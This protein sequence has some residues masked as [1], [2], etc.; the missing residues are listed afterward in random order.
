[1]KRHY[2]FFLICLILSGP[3]FGQSFDTGNQW[4]KNDADRTFIKLVVEEEGIYRVTAQ[5]LSDAGYDVSMVDPRFFQLFH[6]G[7]EVPIFVT[8]ENGRLGYLEF[9]GQLNDGRVDSIMYRSPISGVH[10]PFHQPNIH[11]SIYTDKAA[12]FLTWSQ[13]QPGRRYFD[14]LDLAYSQV[15][16]ESSFRYRSLLDF[17]PE[18]GSP[19]PGIQVIAGGGQYD[20]F[21]SLNS[22]FVTGEGIVSARAFNYN[23]PTTFTI[24]TPAAL[25]QGPP[26]TFETRVFGRSNT[27][28]HLRI[29]VDGDANNPL[30][31]TI[32]NFNSIY[33]RTYTRERIVNL[34]TTTALDCEALR[35]PTD[36]NHLCWAA[37]TYN[38]DFDLLNESAVHMTDWEKTSRSHFRFRN[39]DGQDSVFAYDLTNGVRSR[40][41]MTGTNTAEVIIFESTAAK[42]QLYFTTDKGIKSPVIEEA[43]LNKLFDPTAGA[44]FVIVSHPSLRQAAEAYRDYRDTATANPLSVKLVYVDEIYD[45]F[46]YG[47]LTPWAIKRFCK[48]AIDNWQIKPRFFLF[49]GKGRTW[50]RGF[51]DNLVPTFG[52]PASDFEFVGNYR[53]DTTDVIPQAAVGRVN[54][55]DNAEAFAYLEKVKEHEY[56]TFQ[57]WMKRGVFLGGGATEGEQNAIANAFDYYINEFENGPYGGDAVYFQ[58]RTQGISQNNDAFYHQ[59]ISDGVSLIHFFGHSSSCLLYTSDAADDMQW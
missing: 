42:R 2:L 30:V 58:K 54:A 15:T 36:N 8:S 34:G 21:H 22:D 46:G 6:G 59:E 23:R 24:P 47:S 40:G 57:P 50:N 14:H 44:E 13:V 10:Q 51:D 35:A 49:L 5:E 9:Y 7:E 26:V 32:I 4:Y 19:N 39:A 27:E 38:R 25:N 11:R 29:L 48:E 1:M 28:H 55:Y 53:Q 3:A 16:V 18:A 33:T 37:I 41:L 12:Y 20:S 17:K 31:D 45:E 56:S 52:Y 43:A